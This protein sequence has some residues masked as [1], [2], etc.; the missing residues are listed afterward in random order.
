ME[1]S[2]GDLSDSYFS[3]NYTCNSLCSLQ[4]QDSKIYSSEAPLMLFSSLLF[5]VWWKMFPPDLWPGRGCPA[6]S[7]AGW[8]GSGPWRSSGGKHCCDTRH[9]ECCTCGSEYTKLLFASFSVF[10]MENKMFFLL[11]CFCFIHLQ[12]MNEMPIM[13]TFRRRT[14][15]KMM[16][17]SKVRLTLANENSSSKVYAVDGDVDG[18]STIVLIMRQQYLEKII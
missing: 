14:L 11:K 5:T 10:Y 15:S 8:P 2:Y 12:I 6:L 1:K 7:L 3:N 4:I 16:T 17:S 9:T 13:R 18:D